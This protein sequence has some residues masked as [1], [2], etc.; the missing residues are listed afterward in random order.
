MTLAEMQK[1]VSRE[2]WMGKGY[3]R[4][5]GWTCEVPIR[6]PI[7]KVKKTDMSL[8]FRGEV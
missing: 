4:S 6:H 2:N 1:I 8:E 5:S 3:I 7:D